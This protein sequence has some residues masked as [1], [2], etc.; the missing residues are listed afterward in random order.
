M[1]LVRPVLVVDD[2]RSAIGMIDRMTSSGP[3]DPAALR[4]LD[5]NLNR[6]REALRVVEE[7]A[8]FALED[9]ALSA[10][11]KELRHDL[12]AAV[13]PAIAGWLARG[14]DTAADV[15]RTIQ[16]PTEYQRNSTAAVATAS[17]ARLAEALRSLEE[18][19]KTIDEDFAQSIERLRYRAYDWEQ[20]LTLTLRARERFGQAKLYVILTESL[21]ANEW[22]STA[23]AALDGGADVLQLREKNLPD[24]EHL[25]RATR[26]A[27]LCRERGRLFIVNDR[28]DIAVMSRA[29]GVHLG[30]E[31]LPASLVRRTMPGDLLIGVSTHTAAQIDA[32]I[33]QAPDYIAVGPMFDS[34]TKPQAHVAGPQT[35]A[36][37]RAKTS[38]PLVAIG[39]INLTNVR[40]VLATANGCVCVCSSVIGQEDVREA[41]AALRR[42]IDGIAH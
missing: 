42:A 22:H 23:E 28:P 15:G 1:P 31:D 35:L 16:T 27:N 18:Y 20:R 17:A 21:C 12:V 7:F 30:Q 8:R 40:E 4:I 29:H 9:P 10:A 39:G 19:G 13:P 25:A 3:P 32:A 38:L 41:A 11:A 6:A 37:A 5:A 36:A 2:G 24:A 14:R 34:P 33:A 26:L